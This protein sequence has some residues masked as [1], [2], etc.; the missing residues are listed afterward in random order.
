MAWNTPYHAVRFS[1]TSS[2]YA[3]SNGTAEAGSDYIA[4]SGTLTIKAGA[5][6]NTITVVILG[7]TDV[8]QNETFTVTLN[9]PVVAVI[10]RAKAT[11]TIANDD[12]PFGPVDE[13][14][15]WIRGTWRQVTV[16]SDNPFTFVFTSEQITVSDALGA[17][18]HPAATGSVW[19]QMGDGDSYHFKWSGCHTWHTA[20]ADRCGEYH[21]VLEDDTLGSAAGDGFASGS[22]HDPVSRLLGEGPSYLYI[23]RLSKVD[24]D[25]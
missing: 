23:G 4:A 21:F 19:D 9:Q 3:T 6:L 10:E 22:Y 16:A 2:D 17:R 24:D 12:I 13:P 7:D 15:E 20:F 14:P 25:G 18:V 11:G 8:E 1:G 5:T